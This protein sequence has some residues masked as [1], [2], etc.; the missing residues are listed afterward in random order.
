MHNWYLGSFTC[1]RFREAA[2]Q[3]GSD[4]SRDSYWYRYKP[5][6]L[7]KY[8]YLALPQNKFDGIKLELYDEQINL[9]HEKAR[10][11]KLLWHGFYWPTSEL[12]HT[13]YMDKNHLQVWP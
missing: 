1:D 9:N 8:N 2:T 7:L 12:F 5:L 6:H 4:V 3:G 10:T 11:S 13:E